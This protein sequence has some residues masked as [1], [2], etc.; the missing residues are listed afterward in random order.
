MSPMDVQVSLRRWL[1][2]QLF[3]DLLIG[4][5]LLL[6]PGLFLGAL[7][8]RC[9]DPASARLLG[10]A[11]VAMGAQSYLARAEG[12]EVIRVLL[13]LRTL[14]SYAGIVALVAAVGQGAPP[15]AWALLSAFVAFAGVWTHYRIRIKQ[16]AAQA[17]DE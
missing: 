3:L 8:W 5:P 16:L 15:A 11:M 13:N 10:A 17:E 9:V 7:G 12:P 14:W 6:A 2:A 1:G 4:L